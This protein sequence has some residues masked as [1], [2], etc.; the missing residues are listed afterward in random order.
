MLLH[1]KLSKSSCIRSF[2]G[3]K[4]DRGTPSG[5]TICI[6]EPSSASRKARRSEIGR[7][8]LLV[9]GL[10]FAPAF[11]ATP[12]LPGTAVFPASALLASRHFPVAILTLFRTGAAISRFS[13]IDIG[14]PFAHDC[15]PDD[16]T[17]S[18]SRRRPVDNNSAKRSTHAPGYR[19]SCPI[20]AAH[21]GTSCNSDGK[22]SFGRC[23]FW[24][25]PCRSGA[26]CGGTRRVRCQDRRRQ[27]PATA[28][29]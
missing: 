19:S 28:P 5:A 25:K 29:G 24:L 12:S 8:V 6:A 13:S 9:G 20:L 27:N 16:D 21:T 11:H 7:R 15:L 14:T 17:T 26:G 2:I 10:G 18:L 3:S 23:R 1:A 22:C 4:L